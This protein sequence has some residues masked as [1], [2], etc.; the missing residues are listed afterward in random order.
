LL[1]DQTAYENLV[2]FDDEADGAA[3]PAELAPA[4]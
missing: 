1:A 3:G 4:W 2:S